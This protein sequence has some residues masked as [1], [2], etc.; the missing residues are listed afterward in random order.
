[1]AGSNDFTGQNIQDTYQRVLQLS[2]SGQLADGTGSLVTLLET[3]ASFA[4]VT[5]LAITASHALFAVSAS[6]E[7]TFEVSSSHA[8][9][10][11]SASYVLASNIDQPFTNITASGDISASG[12]NHSFGGPTFIGN[13]TNE[14]DSNNIL[15]VGGGSGTAIKLYST[16]TSTGRDVGL[17]MSASAN[18]QEYSIGLA[19]TQ[20]A[21]Y[22]A[23]TGPTIGP[24]NAVFKLSATGDITASGNISSSGNILGDVFVSNGISVLNNPG[25]ATSNTTLNSVSRGLLV[26]GTKINLNAEVTA[27][28]GL[29]V[30][31]DVS[32]S[33]S[34]SF[35]EL[36]IAQSALIGNT[37]SASRI[38]TVE[39]EIHGDSHP[40]GVIRAR[41][42]TDMLILFQPNSSLN[43]FVNANNQVAFGDRVDINAG[44][45][46][47]DT[48]I[49]GNTH[50]N[51]FY[52]NAGTDK[53]GI[54]T[55]NPGHE[56]EVSGSIS[57]SG[58]LIG[59]G[60][61][62]N[63]TTTF[64]DGNITNVGNIDVDQVRADA[65]TSTLIGVGN[66]I[67]SD[68]VGGAN[69][70][71][72]TA[73]SIQLGTVLNSMHVTAS[74]N[75]SSSATVI[76]N[77]GSFGS[78]AGVLS[79]TNQPN[80]TT[81][82]LLDSLTVDG[83][84][85]ANGNITGDGGT[86]ITA[87]NDIFLD[88]VVHSG[89]T[90]TKIEFDTDKITF[91]VGN[92]ALLTLT[93]ASS[94][95]IEFG[96][97]ISSNITASANISASTTSTIQAGTGSYHIL[98]G[99]TSQPTSLLVDG[100]I[101]ASGNISSSGTIIGNTLS[102]F[103]LSNQGSEATSIMIDGNGVVGTRELG[104]N[105]FTSTTIGTTTNALTVDNATLQLNSGTT[106]DGSAAKTISVKDGGIDSDALAANIAV[107]QLSAS[108]M[109]ASSLIIKGGS[110]GIDITGT[111]TFNDGNITNV[112]LIDVDQIQADADSSV[113][114]E[115]S[116]AGLAFN[117]NS[118]DVFAFNT[119]FEAVDLTYQDSNEDTI[120]KIDESTKRIGVGV[121]GQD[122]VATLDVQGNANIT[123]HITASGNISASAGSI[124][125]VPRR[126]LDQTV[127]VSAGTQAQGDIYYAES[128]LSTT[129]G[130]IYA[131]RGNGSQAE[132]DK[133]VEINANALLGVAIGT[134]SSTDG[135]LLRGMVK[136]ATNPFPGEVAL[137]NPAYLGDSG[138][139]TGSIA[140]HASDDFI[141]IIG[142]GI[143]SGGVIYFNPD[144]TFI[145][146]A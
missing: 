50:T 76:G 120:F 10:A 36:S 129:P 98:Q 106:F 114:I 46:D 34:G 90:D 137:G 108:V 67:I 72:Q 92:T 38:Q 112:G 133:D 74:G 84:I 117:V 124:L 24:E 115:L 81:V 41:E 141:R 110:G 40:A 142:H 29:E 45:S 125:S 80:I 13:T 100:Q 7:V 53:I 8:Q 78:I 27:S 132:A 26:Q 54:R 105:A 130:K 144:N 88:S 23:P 48:R 17:H 6:H 82:G 18:G 33:A 35:S 134:N 123:S 70:I 42:D 94:D 15:A 138:N 73:T 101:T 59:G 31:G 19:R 140:G 89:D 83:N 22:I 146:K 43:F 14:A 9:T 79:T 116:G 52:A 61:N 58:D 51:L 57:A 32:A 107:T 131:L 113:F 69:T 104:S 20:N 47:F 66:G 60:L 128:N 3:T 1:M 12:N 30:I 56:L 2:S 4:E 11:D 121:L 5:T 135:Y 63:G 111:T 143:K 145:K 77:S 21:F 118:G 64:N 85:N 139:A 109:T 62:I 103:G 126:H 37:V 119:S 75:I 136:L 65:D 99:D 25:G 127:Q 39:L 93:E 49:Q 122:P 102:L 91:T 16:H 87:I 71:V 97:T 28:Q 95:T 86:D 96:A 44:G 68:T 55:S